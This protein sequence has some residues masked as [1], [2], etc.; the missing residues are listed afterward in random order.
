LKVDA[1]FFCSRVCFSA[2]W[3]ERV[4]RFTLKKRLSIPRTRPSVRPSA[5][6]RKPPRRRSEQ[7]ATHQKIQ[8]NEQEGRAA[9]QARSKW[10]ISQPRNAE[11]PLSYIIQEG[12]C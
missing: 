4:R 11:L 5:V 9:S 10:W 12:S 6:V 7:P 2:G 1:S 8:P 3:E